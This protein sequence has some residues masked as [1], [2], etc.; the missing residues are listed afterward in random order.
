ML[1][2]KYTDM[3]DI[4]KNYEFA[5]RQMEEGLDTY[6]LHTAEGTVGK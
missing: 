3:I 2:G 4:I 5:S 6:Q 1:L